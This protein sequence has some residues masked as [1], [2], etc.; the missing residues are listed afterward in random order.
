MWPFVPLCALFNNVFEMRS[1][2]FKLAYVS[3]RPVPRKARSIGLFYECFKFI[4][5]F[6]IFINLSLACFCTGALEW[7][8]SVPIRKSE[9][10]HYGEKRMD[11]MVPNFVDVSTST[12]FFVFL[13]V[14]HVALVVMYAIR[15]S[16]PT[17]PAWVHE[18][19][20]QEEVDFKQKFT[21]EV[22]NRQSRKRR[23]HT[24]SGSSE[25]DE[26]QMMMED[27]Q[28]A[29]AISEFEG[30]WNHATHELQSSEIRR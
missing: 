14:E 26:E 5:F 11:P 18:K 25:L 23:Q 6:S 2:A 13:V 10:I 20:K 27:P 17:L 12:R 30:K 9:M 15:M 29:D 22:R 8:L 24:Q 1:S 19:M 16:V 3:S 4:N 7:F 21:E 28:L